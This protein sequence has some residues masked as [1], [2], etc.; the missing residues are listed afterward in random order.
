MRRLVQAGTVVFALLVSQGCGSMRNPGDITPESL[1]Q[2]AHASSESVSLDIYWARTAAQQPDWHTAMW[3]SVQED[4]IPVEVR[5]RLAENGLRA[6]V[7]GGNPNTTIARLLNPDPS[8]SPE[9]RAQAALSGE[10]KVT[11]RLMPLRPH[12]RGEVQATDS[13]INCTVIRRHDG[14]LTGRPYTTAQGIYTLELLRKEGDRIELE[15]TPE[16]QHGLPKMQY[17]TAGPGVV[18]QRPG[19]ETEVF[20]DLATRVSLV[21]GEMLLVAPLPDAGSKLGGMF[22][23]THGADGPQQRILMVRLSQV[24][25]TKSLAQER[26]AWPWD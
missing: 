8:A 22:H 26:T 21:S 12:Q 15:L 7:V 17:T 10:A 16:V 19:R 2:T 25:R 13:A 4:R 20:D 5:R 18:I 23:V 3:E 6:G 11:R 24:P 9:E 14:E 1:L